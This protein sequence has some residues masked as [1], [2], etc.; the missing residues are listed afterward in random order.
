MV[1][2]QLGLTAADGLLVIRAHA[3]ASARSVR[4]VAADIVARRIGFAD[5]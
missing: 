5:E 4:E 1:L 2:A 3:Y